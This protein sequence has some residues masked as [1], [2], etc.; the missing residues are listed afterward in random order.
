MPADSLPGG[1][2]A[3]TSLALPVLGDR[4]PNGHN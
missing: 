1:L 3:D 4:P 2:M